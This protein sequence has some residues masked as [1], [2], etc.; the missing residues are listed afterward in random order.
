MDKGTMKMVLAKAKRAPVNCAAGLSQDGRFGLLLM[1]ITRKPKALVAD[2]IKAI[3]GARNIRWGTAAVD[4][5]TDPKVVMFQLNKPLAGLDRKLRKTLKVAG[6]T[7]A[8]IA[9]QSKGEE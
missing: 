4:V 2:L 7:K 1:H 5:E 9:D 6:Y 3:P 8:K